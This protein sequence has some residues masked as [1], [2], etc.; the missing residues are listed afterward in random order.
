MTGHDSLLPPG[1][2]MPWGIPWGIRGRSAWGFF[3]GIPWWIP[4]GNPGEMNA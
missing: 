3:R 4:Q 1:P 2:G